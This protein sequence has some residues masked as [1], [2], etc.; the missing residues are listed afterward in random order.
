M[1]KTEAKAIVGNV[2]S[3]TYNADSRLPEALKVAGI[4]RAEFN[5]L[6]VEAR[7]VEVRHPRRVILIA[8]GTSR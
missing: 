3:G 6:L 5:R 7:K 2:W 1:N 8:A 4:S